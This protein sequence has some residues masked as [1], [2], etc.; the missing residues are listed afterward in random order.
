MAHWVLVTGVYPA[1]GEPQWVRILNS[2][3]QRVEYYP[4][5]EFAANLLREARVQRGDDPN[6]PEAPP[7]PY[8]AGVMTTG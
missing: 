6:N 7:R 1:T 5:G 3:N 8:I 2:I 4:A